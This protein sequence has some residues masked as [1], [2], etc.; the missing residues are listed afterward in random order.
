M[1]W[2]ESS[3]VYQIYP[4]GLCGAPAQ[5]DFSEQPTHRIRHILDAG[6]LDH[7]QQMGCTCLLLN[8]L[9]ESTSHG[10][11]TADY[12]KV[13]TR[14]GDADDVAALVAAA[15]ARG[16]RVLFDAVLNHVG[17]DFWAF[18][19]VQEKGDKSDFAGWFYLN[20]GQDNRFGDGFSYEGWEGVDTLVRLNHDNFELNA[21]LTEVIRSW[22]RTFDIDGLRLDVAYCLPQGYL[23]YLREV[24]DD[25]GRARSERAGHDSEFVLVGECMFGDYNQWM[26][27]VLCHSVTNYEA[28][29]GLWS[30]V[31]SHNMHEIAYAMHRQSGSDPWCL[32]TGRH[33]L[34]FVD[35][36][37]VDRIATKLPDKR[38]LYPL[39]G[40]LFGM[41]GVPALYYG[42]EW[43]L[44]GQKLPGDA[45]LRPALDHPL[46][47]ELTEWISTL[48]H[49]R[50]NPGPVA[51][52]LAYGAY[53]QLF[54]GPETLVFERTT[55]QARLIV[56]INIS[57]QLQHISWGE[58]G[59]K[60][61]DVVGGTTCMLEGALELAPFS[62]TYWVQE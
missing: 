7:I 16:I 36:H 8:P 23:Y 60:L 58:S 53:K 45:E 40:L 3:V 10:Y 41:Y 46:P 15:H 62:A 35:N 25:I 20:F 34:N 57:D 31:V 19:D 37:D 22:E 42:S 30:S 44:E 50:T 32:Y 6:W 17:R 43:G 13:D 27:D 52:T 29:K 55:D 24:V 54:V 5:N 2:F 11:D 33:L 18:K 49:L 48:A 38:A 51:D 26:G 56:A 12:L 47:N 39:Y 28:Y 61:R 21:Y 1:S 9:F 59:I 14:L 4:L